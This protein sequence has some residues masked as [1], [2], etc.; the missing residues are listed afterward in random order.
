M[1]KPDLEVTWVHILLLVLL[2]A[3]AVI[4]AV[5]VYSQP[6]ALFWGGAG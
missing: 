2:L 5:L 1:Q 3:L 4:L 6:A